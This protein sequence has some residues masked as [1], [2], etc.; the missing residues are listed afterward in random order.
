M[1]DVNASQI[2]STSA[3]A[4]APVAVETTESDA[5]FAVVDPDAGRAVV[6][7]VRRRAA[8]VETESG[9]YY[10][11]IEEIR[12][13]VIE[14][15]AIQEQE[16]AE[17]DEGPKNTCDLTC[18]GADRCCEIST[19]QVGRSGLSSVVELESL[20]KA[21]KDGRRQLKEKVFP[22]FST[23]AREIWSYVVLLYTV[24]SLVRGIVNFVLND[25]KTTINY[26]D[27]GVSSAS[28]VL[29]LLNLFIVIYFLRCRL[30]RDSCNKCRGIPLEQETDVEGPCDNCCKLCCKNKFADLVRMLIVDLLTYPITICSIF[31]LLLGIK[32]VQGNE[33]DILGIILFSVQTLATMKT[34]YLTRFLGIAKT[35]R[36]VEEARKDGPFLN[37]A[38]WFH[39]HFLLHVIGQIMTQVLMVVCIGA[40]FYYENRNLT[41]NSTVL[42]NGSAHENASYSTTVRISSYLWY[43]IIGGLVIP[44]IGVLTFAISNFH[45]VQEYPIGFFLDV[46]YTM[47]SKKTEQDIIERI[48]DGFTVIHNKCW[49]DKYGYVFK[50][51]LLVTL[52]IIYALILFGFAL[53]CVVDTDQPYPVILVLTGGGKYVALYGP[54]LGWTVFFVVGV[55]LVNIAN[56]L[57]L[58]VAGVWITIIVIVILLIF[59]AL[60]ILLIYL[61]CST[62]CK[63]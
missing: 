20:R 59:F 7:N 12:L 60:L 25:M 31:E 45:S 53:C 38:R 34:V 21:G 28:S 35:V 4:T 33:Y 17:E 63:E 47:D 42:G 3:V 49:L 6:A 15:G 58:L 52:S 24:I 51:P 55:V 50:S 37:S 39:I 2:A 43:M 19:S 5:T 61:V 14:I 56:T 41:A 48:E 40:K 10:R 44:F 1:A 30:V 11:E 23:Y 54:S 26:V 36:A 18:R 22:L 9:I 62:Q 29:S 32:L 13:A 27:I 46:L 16:A 57:V 8:R